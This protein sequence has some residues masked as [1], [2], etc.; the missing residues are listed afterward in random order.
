MNANTLMDQL[1]QG[2]VVTVTGP[3]EPS[4]LG[5]VMMHEHVLVDLRN[6]WHPPADFLKYRAKA[7]DGP[8]TIDKLGILRRDPLINR[9]N[10]VLDDEE[11]A[12]I[13]LQELSA[14]GGGAV[15]EMSSLGLGGRRAQLPAISVRSGIKIVAGAGFYCEAKL[16]EEIRGADEDAIH[17]LL[18]SELT[19]DGVIAGAIGEM[20]TSHPMTAGEAMRIRVAATVAAE[21]GLS[22][23]IHL[24]SGGRDGVKAAELALEHLNP[25]LLVL[26]HVDYEPDPDRGYIRALADTGATLS[27][28]TF[29]SAH[30]IE[31]IGWVEPRDLE[32]IDLLLWLVETG[33]GERIVVS[34]D[35]A[36]KTML[37]TYGGFGYD[38][39]LR[40]IAPQLRRRGLESDVLTQILVVTPQR[41][42]TIKRF[43]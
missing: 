37:R 23:H 7:A 26:G 22:L 14:A 40:D 35:V 38:H 42:L 4:Q 19:N 8:V 33:Y 43:P 34:H 5:N 20:G 27:L 41:V 39:F 21:L 24:E 25:E 13:E 9:H 12:V 16:S 6:W 10:L 2:Q 11:L 15:I 31:S 32:R 3:V 28:D 1:P 18:L 29:G 36:I 17:A 30:Y